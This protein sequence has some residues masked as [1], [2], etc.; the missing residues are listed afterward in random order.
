LQRCLDDKR[1]QKSQAE[2][3]GEVETIL[4]A[5]L[6]ANTQWFAQLFVSH[7][8]RT[9]LDSETDEDILTHAALRS[10]PGRLQ[11]LHQRMSV[12]ERKRERP[13]GIVQALGEPADMFTSSQMFFYDFL[14][15]AD[16]V[17]F[18]RHTENI[19]TMHL[20]EQVHFF[21]FLRYCISPNHLF[22]S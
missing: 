13:Q 10:D 18:C 20:S 7:L 17:H 22:D 4:R 2:F 16:S 6:P 9:A 19:L 3:R 14:E 11:K 12:P 15:T 8:A 1:F 5:L 21:F